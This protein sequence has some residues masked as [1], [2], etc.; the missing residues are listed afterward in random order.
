MP[1]FEIAPSLVSAPLLSL[2]DSLA[3]LRSAGVQKL[4]IDIEDGH[5]VPVMNLGTRFIEELRGS[6]F[7]LDVHL[8]VSNPE[9]II[10]LAARLGADAI[11]V[12]LEASL[13]PRRHLSAIRSL[14]LQ[15]GLAV[16]PKTPLPDLDYLA[17]RL[18]SLLVLTT[19]PEDPH[20]PFIPATLNKIRQARQWAAQAAPGLPITAD[21]GVSADNLSAV[22]VA[23]ASGV[24]VGRALFAGADL[25]RSIE[26][27]R[28]AAGS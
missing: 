12:H 5:F 9:E 26:Q 16:N 11:S 27:L 6:G 20:S 15:A 8:M 10:P 18:D 24:V 3:Q 25:Q 23:G 17:D 13:Y 1:A 2:S 19:E 28:K 14:G 4:H 21:G 7:F 22:L